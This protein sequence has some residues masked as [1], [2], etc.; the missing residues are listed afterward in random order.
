MNPISEKKS[1]FATLKQIGYFSVVVLGIIIIAGTIVCSI[2]YVPTKELSIIA[3]TIGS[4][5]GMIFIMQAY[6][7]LSVLRVE[8]EKQNLAKAKELQEKVHNQTHEIHKLQVEKTRL[9]TMRLDVNSIT[10]VLKL[11]LL[12]MDCI[13][14]DFKREKMEIKESI[15]PT[16]LGM[17]VPFTHDHEKMYEYI[18]LLT[19]TFQA[20]IGIDLNK[21]RIALDKD[22][23]IVS[24]IQSEFMGTKNPKINWELYELRKFHKKD[25]KIKTYE[26]IDNESHKLSDA[27]DRQEREVEDRINNGVDLKH[28]EGSVERIGQQFIRLILKPINKEIKFSAIAPSENTFSLIE[29]IASHN[30]EIESKISDLDTKAKQLLQVNGGQTVLSYDALS[31]AKN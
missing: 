31:S 17:K 28:N 16:I 8:N 3:S 6:T 27:K 10:P 21:V 7:K 9:E 22:T 11:V 15:A 23:I 19:K 30:R 25:D 29:F 13:L 20:N 14:K 1:V 5:I 18:G 26:I 12:E 24:G 4:C 2:M